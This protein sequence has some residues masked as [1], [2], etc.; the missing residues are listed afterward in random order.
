MYSTQRGQACPYF[1]LTKKKRKKW[2]NT[3][4]YGNCQLII[5]TDA[6]DGD[7]LTMTLAVVWAQFRV[8]LIPL[9]NRPTNPRAASSSSTCR[10]HAGLLLSFFR[11]TAWNLWKRRRRSCFALL[12]QDFLQFPTAAWWGHAI[13]MPSHAPRL[14]GG[15]RITAS[16]D[17]KP[18]LPRRRPATGVAGRQV[19][20]PT[21]P[22]TTTLAQ[23]ARRRGRS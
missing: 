17:H 11:R 18:R 13:A 21:C 19:P 20:A 23:D 5:W 2:L 9:L 15:G 12:P 10:A 4:K 1:C 8:C 16:A 14:V 7:G 22:A 6:N 3:L